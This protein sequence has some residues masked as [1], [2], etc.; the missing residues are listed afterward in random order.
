MIFVTTILLGVQAAQPSTNSVSAK[1]CE[2]AE[3]TYELRICA[4][5]RVKEAERLLDQQWQATAMRFKDLDAA[6]A[7]DEKDAPKAF[8]TGLAAQRAWLAYRDAQC[9]AEYNEYWGGTMAPLA[10]LNC[11]DR[12]TR[13]RIAELRQMSEP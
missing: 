7:Q 10:Q 6:V 2:D 5:A 8:A 1:S 11:I 12:I 4:S 13:A 9:R 3:T